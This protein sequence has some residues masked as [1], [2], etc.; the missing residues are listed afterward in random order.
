M[1]SMLTEQTI[2]AEVEAAKAKGGVLRSNPLFRRMWAAQT[3]SVFG[4]SITFIAIPTV[5]VL[6]LKASAFTVGALG[7]VSWAAWP[8][9][10]LPVGV[11]VDRLPRRP[12]LVSADLVRLVLIASVPLAWAFGDVAIAQLMVVAAL[13]G[14][15]S[16]IFD[17]TF[18]SA[19]PDVVQPAELADANGRLE[20]SGSTSRLTGPGLAGLLIGAVGAPVALVG[21]AISFALSALFLGTGPMLARRHEPAPRRPFLRDLREGMTALREYWQVYRATFSAAVSNLAWTMGQGIFFVFAYR[22]VHLTPTLVGAAL[23]LASVGNVAGAAAAPALSRKLGTGPALLVSTTFEASAV[24]LMPLGIFFGVPLLWIALSL[25]IRSFFGPLWNVTAATMRQIIVPGPL[26]GRVTAAARTIGMGVTPIG[27]LLGG[28][29]ATLSSPAWALTIS[30][31][32]GASSALPLIS[33]RML[34]VRIAPT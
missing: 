16:V 1:L 21:D 14:A 29:I 5:A 32:V 23:T 31:I 7:A 19:V 27:G 24:L 26:Q 9:I 20:L 28:A 22:S 10:G 18:T 8:L 4:D 12:L 15:C 17:L 30:G 6:T 11:W 34:A 33:R 3:V 25:G 2:T 13:A